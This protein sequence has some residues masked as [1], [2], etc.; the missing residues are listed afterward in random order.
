MKV[1][2]SEISDLKKFISDLNADN[3]T[4]AVEGKR[5]TR[6]LKNIGIRNKI[7]EFHKY[8]GINNFADA[9]AS[10]DKIIILF[11]GDKKGRYLTVK[12][13]EKLQ[14]RTRVDLSFKRRLVLA[15]RGRIRFVEQLTCYEI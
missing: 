11:D 12:A 13:I 10:Y 15:T 1:T 5:D 2:E 4:I 9:V 14:R 8:C 6:A 3:G 7:V